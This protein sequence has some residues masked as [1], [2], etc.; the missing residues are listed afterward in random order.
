ME[1][2]DFKRNYVR[3]F[4]ELDYNWSD[5]SMKYK[6]ENVFRLKLS[7]WEKISYVVFKSL[8]RWDLN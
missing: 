6:F 7:V 5:R 3:K 8:N 2:R 4:L 1:G